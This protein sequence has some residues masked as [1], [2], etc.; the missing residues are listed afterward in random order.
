MFQSRRPGEA[1]Y[2]AL[3]R[4][5]LDALARTENTTRAEALVIEALEAAAR[6]GRVEALSPGRP[7]RPGKGGR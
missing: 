4:E 5:L 7:R 3:A 1:S 6:A 2:H